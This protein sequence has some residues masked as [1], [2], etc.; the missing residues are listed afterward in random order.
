ME[1]C[2]TSLGDLIEQREELLA[3]PLEASKI[4]KMA[5]DISNALNYLHTKAF[6]LHGDLKSYNVLIKNSFEHCKLCDFGVSLPLNN[7]GYLDLEKNPNARYVGTDIYSAPEI[8]N[9]PPQDISSKCDIFSF[10]LIIFEC[11]SLR[12]PHYEH[13]EA[14]D[15]SEFSNTDDVETSL[16]HQQQP[17]KLFTDCMDAKENISIA[18][19]KGLVLK[20]STLNESQN[21]NS[22][23]I[24]STTATIGD[25]TIQDITGTTF[26]DTI[27]SEANRNH[28]IANC[29]LDGS[30]LNYRQPMRDVSATLNST[31][32]SETGDSFIDKS[33][34]QSLNDTM[35]ASN[36][37]S[38]YGT[39]PRIPD[40][41]QFSE[42]YNIC[43]ETFYMC[44]H[45]LPEERPTAGDLLKS[46]HNYQESH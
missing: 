37:T 9:A 35:E 42:E 21:D 24:K 34:T 38:F 23:S 22:L 36:L 8:F 39:R 28:T 40:S 10:G 2:D 18:A 19:V 4:R 31:I 32:D 20:D 44:T 13:L 7:E 46:L 26:N 30:I 43:F 16:I 11:V 6:L 27:N 3:G 17:K 15:H 45:A 25:D 33:T 14:L 1:I 41:L 29:S 12:P 5:I